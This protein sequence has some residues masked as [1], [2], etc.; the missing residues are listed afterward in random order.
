[1]RA[2]LLEYRQ[3]RSIRALA[4]DYEPYEAAIRHWVEAESDTRFD[5]PKALEPKCLGKANKRLREDKLIV[6]RAAAWFEA[7]RNEPE[8]TFAPSISLCKRIRC[9]TKDL[10]YTSAIDILYVSGV[11]FPIRQRRGAFSLLRSFE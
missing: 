1:M 6:E 10:L 11:K 5:V 7:N 9:Q 3:R 2:I 8:T 4:N